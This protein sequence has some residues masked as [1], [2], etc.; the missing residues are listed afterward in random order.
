M[1]TFSSLL[2]LLRWPRS[3][4]RWRSLCDISSTPE[5]A[6]VSARCRYSL[7]TVEVICNPSVLFCALVE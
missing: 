3:L 2:R 6:L 4:P 5:A 1:L 7:S